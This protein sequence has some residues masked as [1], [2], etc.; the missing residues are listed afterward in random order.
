MNFCEQMSLNIFKA[1]MWPVS[2][3]R[4]AERA[5]CLGRVGHDFVVPHGASRPQDHKLLLEAHMNGVREEKPLQA[6]FESKV[7]CLMMAGWNWTYCSGNQ[8]S[9]TVSAS[10]ML[11][12]WVC[13]SGPSE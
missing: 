3:S 13:E 2:G 4:P 9:V 8:G 10:P 7:G 12:I 6:E 5:V 1:Y 11:E